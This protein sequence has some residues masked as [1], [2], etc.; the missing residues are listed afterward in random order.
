MTRDLRKRYEEAT[1]QLAKKFERH[2]FDYYVYTLAEDLPSA[3][4]LVRALEGTVHEDANP[5]VPGDCVDFANW[6]ALSLWTRAGAVLVVVRREAEIPTAIRQA[7]EFY[8]AEGR[9]TG[10]VLQAER[11]MEVRVAGLSDKPPTSALAL[12]SAA[13]ADVFVRMDDAIVF[14]PLSTRIWTRQQWERLMD[15]NEFDIRNFI[16]MHVEYGD[17]GGWVHTHGMRR[18]GKPDFEVVNVPQKRIDSMAEQLY[19]VAWYAAEGAD[20]QEGDTMTAPGGEELRFERTAEEHFQNKALRL[21]G[22]QL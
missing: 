2:L 22:H 4:D 21:I 5:S 20:V 18:F 13:V 14:E 8:D 7:V 3:S 6:H 12:F 17:E 1:L 15:V 11:V 10:A 16:F 19:N 9:Q